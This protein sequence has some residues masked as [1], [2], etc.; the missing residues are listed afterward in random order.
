MTSDVQ[1]LSYSL[2][3]LLAPLPR[4]LAAQLETSLR[5]VDNYVKVLFAQ[6]FRMAV[7]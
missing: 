3:N 4:E 7:D 5:L 6:M 2:K 1:D